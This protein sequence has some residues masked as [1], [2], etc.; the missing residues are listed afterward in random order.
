LRMR[1]GFGESPAAWFQQVVFY[2]RTSGGHRRLVMRLLREG[3]SRGDDPFLVIS[4]GEQLP[5]STGKDLHS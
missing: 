2:G 3:N 5:V 4:I 1:A